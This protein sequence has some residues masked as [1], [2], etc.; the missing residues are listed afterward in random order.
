[1]KKKFTAP[2][3]A[4][5]VLFFVALEA[6]A[7]GSGTHDDP[8]IFGPTATTETITPIIDIDSNIFETFYFDINRPGNLAITGNATPS[9][10]VPGFTGGIFDNTD[11]LWRGK[12]IDPDADGIFELF[13]TD[14]VG[15]LDLSDLMTAILPADPLG[16]HLHFF[17]LGNDAPAGFNYS[18]SLAANPVPLPTSLWLILSGLIGIILISSRKENNKHLLLRQL[19]EN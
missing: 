19:R 7:V 17:T 6:N 1:M 18:F 10:L 15:N 16:Y 13:K 9:A 14:S 11:D 3:L 2:C 4:F 5:T 8:F 12:F